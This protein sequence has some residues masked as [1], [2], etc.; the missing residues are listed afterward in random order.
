MTKIYIA[1]HNIKPA[2]DSDFL[3]YN[4]HLYLVSDPDSNLYT[5]I[6]QKIIRGGDSTYID[7]NFTDMEVGAGFGDLSIEAGVI[8]EFSNDGLDNSY[9]GPDDDYAAN[10]KNEDGVADTI[11]NRNYTEVDISSILTGSG[12][13]D[14][15]AV[16]DAMTTYASSL[17]GQYGYN[18]LDEN[19]QATVVTILSSVGIN[20]ADN[21]PINSTYDQYYSRDKLLDG[22]G[23]SVLTVFDNDVNY[24]IHDR[25]GNDYFIFENGATADIEKDND[26]NTFNNIVLTGYSNL[27]NLYLA[28]PLSGDLEIRSSAI[29]VGSDIVDIHD[30]FSGGYNTKYLFVTAGN[31]QDVTVDT[32]NNVVNCAAILRQIDTRLLED[33]DWNP[34]NGSIALSDVFT[35]TDENPNVTG[36][37]GDEYVIGNDAANTLAGGAGNDQLFGGLGADIADYSQDAAGVT[38]NVL[39]EQ[40]TDGFGN[41]DELDSIESFIGSAYDDEFTINSLMNEV[42]G[43]AGVDTVLIDKVSIDSS[44]YTSDS[45]AINILWK[46]DGSFLLDSGA[47]LKNI[48]KFDSHGTQLIFSAETMGKDYSALI[49]TGSTGHILDYSNYNNGSITVDAVNG[50][51][52]SGGLTDQYTGYANTIVGTN[53]GDTIN[54]NY[55]ASYSAGLSTFYSGTGDDNIYDWRGTYY[56]SGGNDHI[57]KNIKTSYLTG[58]TIIVP[59]SISA[60]DITVEFSQTQFLSEFTPTIRE[61]LYDVVYTIGNLGT[62]TCHGVL[63]HHNGIDINNDQELDWLYGTGTIGHTLWNNREYITRLPV[64]MKSVPGALNYF[65]DSP[66]NGLLSDLP[67]PSMAASSGSSTTNSY[68]GSQADEV[69]NIS[70]A[71]L[72]DFKDGLFLY[73][74]DDEVTGSGYA[75]NIYLGNGN[76]TAVGGAGNDGIYGGFGNDSLLDGGEGDDVVSGGAGDDILV[77]NLTNGGNDYYFGGSGTDTLRIVSDQ[78][79]GASSMSLEEKLTLA[80]QLGEFTL[81]TQEFSDPSISAGNDYKFDFGLYASD[82]E[83]IEFSV[84]NTPDATDNFIFGTLLGVVAD[85]INLGGG[86]DIAFGYGGDDTLNGEEGDD[87]LHGG[88]G[89]DTLNGGLGNDTADYSNERSGVAV[90]L[91]AGTAENGVGDLDT[92]SSIENING[93]DYEDEILG[94]TADNDLFGGG[95]ND[96]IAGGEGV[97]LIKGESGNDILSGGSGIDT[98]HG[99]DGDDIVRHYVSSNLSNIDNYFAGTGRDT[100][101]IYFNTEAQ[102]QLFAAELEGYKTYLRANSDINSDNLMVTTSDGIILSDFER[103]DSFIGG[104]LRKANENIDGSSAAETIYGASDSTNE[105]FNALDGDDVVYANSGNDTLNGGDGYDALFGMDGD[106]TLNGDAGNDFLAGGDGNDRL[107][108]G[109]GHDTLEGGLG[110]D[111]AYAGEGND[112]LVG[113]EGD[114]TLYGEVGNDRLIGGAGDDTLDGGEGYDVVDYSAAANAVTVNLHNGTASDDGDGGSDTLVSI[115]DITGSAGNDVF[116][117]SIEANVLRGEGGDDTLYGESGN[118]YLIGGTG[119]DLLNGGDG[120]DTV[121]YSAAASGVTVNLLDGSV[122]DDGDGSS[123]TLISIENIIGSAGNDT[124]IGDINVNVLRGEGGDDAIYGNSSDDTLYGGSGNDD[125]RGQG[126]IDTYYAGEGDDIIY[127]T[128]GDI[129]Y[130]EAGNDSFRGY[131]GAGLFDGGTDE[132]G[133]WWRDYYHAADVGLA[134]D[135]A[136]GTATDGDG[137]VATL[138]SIENLTGSSYADLLE[139]DDNANT[140]RGGSDF[141]GAID[142]GDTIYGRGG[143]DFLYGDSG[144]DTVYG[145]ADNDLIYGNNGNDLLYGDAGRDTINGGAG[146][147]T[148]RGGSDIDR[149]YGANGDDIFY[150][151]GDQDSMW[152][153]GGADTFI[154]EEEADQDYLGMAYIRDFVE[155]SDSVDLSALLSGYDAATDTLSD[156]INVAQGANTTFQVDRDGVGTAHGWDNVVRLQGNS[157]LGTDV[158]LLVSDGMLII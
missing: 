88:S 46:D 116:V 51:V 43:G 128:Q 141:N 147:D 23:D 9:Q 136:A 86:N 111:I 121:D 11:A 151:D 143:T 146:N 27:N 10:D 33:I 144:D 36:D 96:I 37:T 54:F 47:S 75:E 32:T 98:L 110:V 22:F 5:T 25:A 7:L 109:I 77:Y 122:S 20:F 76:D 8:S 61:Y 81:Y 39:T 84:D 149:L 48:E 52:S 135:L 17:V 157:T 3:N 113:D 150:F 80:E 139:G 104:I 24:E 71:G 93:S 90:D 34:L 142:Q 44:S 66:S 158:D 138:V 12:F 87:T 103:V 1:W 45:P 156:F 72:H 129:A 13:S 123:D 114:D 28:K 49:S 148:L 105:I 97:D 120:V 4:K 15:N 101:E 79:L 18:L 130:G 38:I 57:Y 65:L 140:I 31:I 63:V 56:Y 21:V 67:S 85:V 131:G 119:N 2:A 137:N 132:D 100:L 83:N 153:Q 95:G 19:C 69:I 73:G 68:Y 115:E 92:L 30:H 152:G 6:D 94:D 155:G 64:F 89:S 78:P 154:A 127:S 53:S 117:G 35:V 133:I 16:W 145:G 40:Y 14:A 99:D 42:D 70:S 134:V 112:R 59:D 62:I 91:V 60:S 74:G 107:N 106:D 26:E 125:L 118:D 126:G 102:Y 55:D 41:N 58:G 124:I 82:F 29:N 50:T 108:G